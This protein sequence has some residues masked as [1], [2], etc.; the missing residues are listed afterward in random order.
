MGGVRDDQKLQRALEVLTRC[1]SSKCVSD[2]PVCGTRKEALLKGVVPR[3]EIKVKPLAQAIDGGAIKTGAKT[4]RRRGIKIMADWV[5]F[6]L[7]TVTLD[8]KTGLSCR[9]KQFP[10]VLASAVTVQLLRGG[11]RERRYYPQKLVCVTF[12]RCT[13]VNRV[14]LLTNVKGDQIFYHAKENVTATYRMSL[15][16]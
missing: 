12:S 16:G 13:N 3:S 10:V 6:E 5:P 8:R 4:A 2:F 11:V 9:R 14:Y 1:F 15:G 7:R